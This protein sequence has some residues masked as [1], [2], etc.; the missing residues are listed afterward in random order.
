MTERGL[1]NINVF[2]STFTNVFLFLSRFLRFLTFFIFF[3]NVFYI[4]DFCVLI[5]SLWRS[6]CIT[7]GCCKSLDR[8]LHALM[9]HF[10]KRTSCRRATATICSRPC[11]TRCGPAPAHTRL[12][13]GLRQ[14]RPARLAPSSCG[15]HE[16]WRCTVRDRRRQTDVR[17]HH[18]LI[19]Q[20]RGRVIIKY[21]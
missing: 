8:S 6:V 20:P 9:Y 11:T 15:L 12:T 19:P 4:Y 16:Y 7:W 1:K 3:W 2:Y 5:R 21:W 17:Q 18:C 10:Y 14:R 13:P